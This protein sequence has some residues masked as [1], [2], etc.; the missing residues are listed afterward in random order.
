ME[1]EKLKLDLLIAMM[2][3][4]R[5]ETEQ[6]TTKAE[7][8]FNWILGNDICDSCECAQPDSAE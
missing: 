5:F 1:K 2:N 4:S 6:L 7:E 8:Y 3:N